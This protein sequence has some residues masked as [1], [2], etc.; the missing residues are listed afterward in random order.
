MS[1]NSKAAQHAKVINESGLAI[2]VVA[3]FQL[4][5]LRSHAADSLKDKTSLNSPRRAS[6]EESTLKRREAK[7]NAHPTGALQKYECNLVH[8]RR[9]HNYR[10]GHLLRCTDEEHSLKRGA[11][12]SGHM[13]RG[14]LRAAS[15][16]GREQ[17]RQRTRVSLKLEDKK[18]LCSHPDALTR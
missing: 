10:T 11:D 4:S 9:K 8:K 1:K 13:A 14:Q 6:R 7:A 16:S 12:W 3:I 17:Q 15:G 5:S 2:D 18:S